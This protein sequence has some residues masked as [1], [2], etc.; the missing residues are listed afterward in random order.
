MTLTLGGTTFADKNAGT[1][2]TV[3]GTYTLGGADAGNYQFA[4][5]NATTAFSGTATINQAGLTIVN[6]GTVQDKVYDGTTNAS[7][8]GATFNGLVSGDSVTLGVSG[9]FAD[10]NVGTN[11]A[12]NG[13]YSLTG[14]DSGNYQLTN[15][16]SFSGTAS[17]TPATLT[18]ATAGTVNSKTYDGG[19]SATVLSNGALGG[20][21]GS[22]T[23]TLALGGVSFGN[24]NAGSE[25]VS[26]TYSISGTD[27]GNYQ[28]APGVVTTAFTGTAMINKATLTIAT[29]GTVSD[30]TYDGTTAASV[31]TSGSLGGVVGTD[32]VTLSLGGT[33]FADKNAGTAKTVTGTYTLGGADAGNYQFAS[34]NATTVFS[35]T[36]T[37]NQAGLTI[38]NAGT[39]QDKVYD[40]T[41]N[42]S[43]AG[44]TFNGLVS[45]DSVTLGV[46]GGFADKNV[47]VN[48]AVNGSYSLTGTDSG[49]Y[50]LTN[51]TSFSG[52]ASITPATLTIATAGSVNSKTY[53]GTAAATA[54]S[55][56]ILGGV[57]SGD[58]I[59]L[60]LNGLTFADANA[61]AGKAVTGTYALMGN[62]AGNYQFTG[63]GL[64][65]GFTGSAT[66]NAATLTYVA[67][68][69]SVLTGSSIPALSGMV[70]GFVNGETLAGA[71][72]GSVSWSS[73]ADA[74]SPAGQLCHYR[75]GPHGQQRQLR[76]R[77][78]GG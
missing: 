65:S 34:G 27:A 20:V 12:V 1:A 50:Q 57:V 33:T 48:K 40:G 55:N 42:A 2:K 61:G 62:D 66:I 4:S 72:T 43:I 30:K 8:A 47:G 14:T 53:D 45:G 39:V 51:G 52:I 59:T 26:G 68:S 44:A 54:A 63:G 6:A 41:T 35:G 24:K 74:S 76:V 29:A 71:T 3:T 15:G 58:N 23:V 28:F 5:G 75:L 16:T 37:I 32:G 38:V 60:A 31:L 13:S 36:A 18:I 78:G 21:F 19:T 56:G 67:N 49:N 10:K 22:D 11:K 25:S 9:G 73:T 46:S 17:I 77:A 70:T 64:T 69:A 7:I